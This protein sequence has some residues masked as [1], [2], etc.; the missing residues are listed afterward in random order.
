MKRLQLY[1]QNSLSLEKIKSQENVN[2]EKMDY[3]SI[4]SQPC[5]IVYLNNKRPDSTSIMQID[6]FHHKNSNL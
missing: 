1:Q 6:N 2:L 5:E 4:Y 3:Y